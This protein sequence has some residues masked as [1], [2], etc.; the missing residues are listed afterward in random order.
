M[1][2]LTLIKSR[3][4]GADREA[5]AVWQTSN[6]KEQVNRKN[7]RTCGLSTFLVLQCA[8]RDCVNY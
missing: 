5:S 2:A 6:T 8:T 4:R 3:I 1:K 7:R